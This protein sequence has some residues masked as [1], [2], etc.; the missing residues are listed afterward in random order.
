VAQRNG[1]TRREPGVIDG[2]SWIHGLGPATIR[3]S[4]ASLRR[5]VEEIG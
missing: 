1:V 5:I 3:K 4:V 2:V